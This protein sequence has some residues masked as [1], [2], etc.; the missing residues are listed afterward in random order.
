VLTRRLIKAG[1]IM[2]IAVLDHIV[3]AER[4]FHSLRECGDL[5]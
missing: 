5:R 4:G 2:G 1:E 3:L